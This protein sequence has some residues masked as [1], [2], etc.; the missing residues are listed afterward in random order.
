MGSASQSLT[1]LRSA[2]SLTSNL[3]HWNLE[4]GGK[5]EAVPGLFAASRRGACARGDIVRDTRSGVL[6][7]FRSSPQHSSSNRRAGWERLGIAGRHI[8]GNTHFFKLL[9]Q[10]HPRRWKGGGY[11][12]FSGR[13]YTVIATFPHSEADITLWKIDGS[14]PEFARLYEKGDEVGKPLVVFGRGCQRGPEVRLNG[15]LKGWAWGELD[16][17]LRWG[18]NVVAGISDA[19]GNPATPTTAFQLLRA[20]FDLDGEPN[21]AHLSGGDSSGGV[22]LQDDGI[23]K[24]AGVNHAANREYRYGASDESFNATLFDEGGFFEGEE[25][26]DPGC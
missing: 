9:R 4:R 16:G 21:E 19:K 3:T 20:D 11:V 13:S 25:R 6:L 26:E 2:K 24:L 17:M 23:W 10:C 12:W 8:R 15:E 5:I 1:V 22:F 7:D 18:E 14:F